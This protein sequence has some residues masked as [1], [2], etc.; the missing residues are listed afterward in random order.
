M[1]LQ[2]GSSRAHKVIEAY[3]RQ[4]YS[5]I[6]SRGAVGIV[7]KMI[8]KRM[9][10]PFNN[11]SSDAILEVG[12]GAGEHIPYVLDSFKKYY[13]T[14]IDTSGFNLSNKHIFTIV[15][16]IVIKKEDVTNLSFDN[17]S[18]DRTIATCVLVHLYEP[19]LAILELKRVTKQG[20]FITI[21][22][23]CEPGFVLRLAQKF[24]TERKM[25]KF[26]IADSRFL[27]FYEHRSNYFALDYFI[28]TLLKGS[29]IKK[30][31]Y[32]FR[33]SVMNLNLFCVYQIKVNKIGEF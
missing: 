21:Y 10:K 3:Y 20:G 27:H 19:E 8:H 4:N 17:D 16:E 2:M 23:P 28:K 1:R 7:W 5:D 12:S 14:D 26:G 29:V 11:S 9:E 31:F 25:K 24:I 32:P 22:V 13:L 15:G 30:T 33:I 6:F 18:F